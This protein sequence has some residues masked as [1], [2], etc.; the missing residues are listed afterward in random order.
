MTIKRISDL[1]LDRWLSYYASDAAHAALVSHVQ[2]R[3]EKEYALAQ[4]IGVTGLE[5]LENGA[6][7][8]VAG[9]C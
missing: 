8:S 7:A 9:A 5:R 1:E 3:Q 2:S 4:C 6:G